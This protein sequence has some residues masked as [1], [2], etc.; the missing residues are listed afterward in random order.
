MNEALPGVNE[1][2]TLTL[3]HQ[4]AE[5]IVATRH[6]AIP[7]EAR[8]AAKLIMLD[9]LAVAWAGAEAPGCRSSTS[10]MRG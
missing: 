8:V 1:A 3:S 2:S 5:H 9:T 6:D 10:A 7:Q 4:L